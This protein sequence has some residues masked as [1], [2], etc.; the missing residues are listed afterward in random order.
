MTVAAKSGRTSKV[1][2]G[3][4]LD[5]GLFAVAGKKA[6]APATATATGL[7]PITQTTKLGFECVTCTRC[8]GSG[9]FSY[10]TYYGTRCFKCAG[11]KVIFTNRG[12]ISFNKYTEK[13]DV[14]YSEVNAGMKVKYENPYS[15]V[16]TWYTVIAVETE[17]TT[18][19]IK[20]DGFSTSGGADHSIRIARTTE[21]K[22]AYLKAALEYQSTL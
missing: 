21:E 4:M 20:C 5:I 7:A 8:G 13:M 9:S 18:V 14:K 15:G 17:G 1:K 22:R 12:Q 3:Q 11:A 6:P 10:C 16:T 2:L 19:N